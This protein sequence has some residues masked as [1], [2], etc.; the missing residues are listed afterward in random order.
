MK[1]ANTNPRCCLGAWPSA[2][3]KM[4][5]RVRMVTTGSEK[6]RMSRKIRC[7][8]SCPQ[9]AITAARI[10]ITTA[11]SPALQPKAAFRP[12]DMSTWSATL[13]AT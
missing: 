1:A 7:T 12:W 9:M 11:T 4:T 3:P 2:A 5:P 6:M 8:Q 13:N 10:A